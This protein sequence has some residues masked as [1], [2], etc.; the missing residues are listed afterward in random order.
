VSRPEKVDAVRR[1]KPH[2]TSV[3][4]WGVRSPVIVGSA[5]TVKVGVTCSKCDLAGGVVRVQ[6][7]AGSV[8]SEGRVGRGPWPGTRGLHVAEMS[9]IAP[10]VEGLSRW[11][12]S[13]SGDGLAL[14]HES[15]S[16]LFGFRTVEA[17]ERTVRVEVTERD[18]GAPLQG[19]SVFA[20]MYHSVTDARGFAELRVPKGPYALVARKRD[21]EPAIRT[22]GVEG[23]RTISIQMSVR[24]RR[25]PD[26]EEVWM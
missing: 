6:D 16:C 15:S 26:E 3:A 4:V 12:G 14:P 18:S 23:D 13:F 17:P 7:E 10:A 25:E 24:A 1:A 8:V 21:W 5:F 2:A 22:L 11:S 9:L 19:V 20:G